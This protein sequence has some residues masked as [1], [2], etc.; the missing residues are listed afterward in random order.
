MK[1]K[2][3]AL[4]VLAAMLVSILPMA[5]FAAPVAAADIDAA[6]SRM[7]VDTEKADADGKDEVE[8]DVMLVDAKTSKGLAEKEATLYVYTSRGSADKFYG[9][10]VKAYDTDGE[11]ADLETGITR[12]AVKTDE[13]GWFTLKVSSELAGSR[14]FYMSTVSAAELENF[15]NGDVN[16]VKAGIVPAMDGDVSRDYAT[17]TFVASDKYEIEITGQKNDV[18][19]NGAKYQEVTVTVTSNGMPVSGQKVTFS[20]N[21]T[22]ANLAETEKTTDSKGQAKVKLTATKPGTYEVTAKVGNKSDNKESANFTFGAATINTVK[23]MSDDN[24][25]VALNES[26]VSLKFAFYDANGNRIKL[27]AE[28]VKDKEGKIVTAAN[29]GEYDKDGKHEFVGGFLDG[30]TLMTMAKPSGAK[31][32]DEIRI[33]DLFSIT[34]DSNNNLQVKIDRDAINKE[35]DYEIK[36]ALVNGSSATYKFTVKEQGTIT[37]MSLKYDTTSLAAETGAKTDVPTVK[38]LDAEGYGKEVNHKDDD[39]KFSID[40]ASVATISE[41]GVVTEDTK[42]PAVITVTAIDSDSKQV[43]TATINIVKKPSAL[44]VTPKSSYSISEDAAIDVQIVDVDGKPVSFGQADITSAEAEV[45]ILSAPTGAVASG[46]DVSVVSNVKEDGKF[47]VEVNSNKEGQVKAQVILTV[48]Y[49]VEDKDGKKTSETK[50]LTGS[51]I[52]NFGAAAV[53]GQNII[54]MINSSSYLVGGVPVAGTSVPFIENGRTYL[55]I[56]DMAYSM[57]ITGEENVK[58]DNA[59]QTATI[60]KDGIVVEVTVGA[61]AIKVTKNNVTTE[62]AIDAPAKNV[63]GRVFLPF[64]AVFEA[65]GYEVEYANGVITCI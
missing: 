23:K 55:G 57:G 18:P 36:L 59:T 29:V 5:A 41:D 6:S 35:G 52:V 28:D 39:I 2:V 33:E 17:Y 30:A 4:V 7:V 58:W 50:I 14:K 54:F 65:F 16:S 48:E 51:T 44:V 25:K 8:I 43:A 63:S 9:D 37:G 11:G 13:S 1:K 64:R 34:T 32:H 21:K 56:R 15:V 47:S 20:V 46:D 61:S 38:L 53:T 26:E 60:T 27:Y 31:I 49:N 45:I 10:N 19:A 3:L 62:V 24:Q 40:N 42:D 12:L 22:G